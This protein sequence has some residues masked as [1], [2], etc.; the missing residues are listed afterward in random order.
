MKA[1]DRFDELDRVL[2]S[3]LEAPAEQ[4]RS[5]AHQLCEGDAEMLSYLEA[6]LEAARRETLDP[7][8]LTPQQG[9]DR[10]A[11]DRLMGQELAHYRISAKLGEGG[12][13]VVYRALDTKLSREVALK[14]L[15]AGLTHDSRRLARFR[16]EAQV[17]ASLNHP[18]IASIYGL[19]E[20]DGVQLLVMEL[21]PGQTLETRLNEGALPIDD[22][23]EICVQISAA[24]HAAHTAGIVHRDLKPANI[25]VTTDDTGACQVK[26][27]DFGLAKPIE[28]KPTA[29]DLSQSPTITQMTEAGVILGTA[30]YMS[31]EQWRG[32]EVDERTDVWAVGCILFELLTG[33]RAFQGETGTDIAAAVIERDPDFDA[34]PSHAPRRLHAI[35][36]HCLAK[37]RQ[38]RTMSAR[39]IEAELTAIAQDELQDTT[40]GRGSGRLGRRTLIAAFGTTVLALLA[41]WWQGL[42]PN[43]DPDSS[44]LITSLAVLPF[45]DASTGTDSEY[46]AA[47]ITDDLI[48]RLSKIDGLRV[49]PRSVVYSAVTEEKGPVDVAREL[50]VEA[51]VSGLASENGDRLVVSAEL[52]RVADLS[53]L[54]SDRVDGRPV[55]RSARADPTAR[56]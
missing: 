45:E 53:L 5:L 20:V 41:V 32:K 40:R 1:F 3:V 30:H 4:Q 19:E 48:H 46:L 29:T 21:A 14:L 52:L 26:V 15:P 38:Q 33:K 16:R 23:L 13:G 47:G 56:R 12:I 36:R 28:G 22:T 42:G 49:V 25:H 9:A 2:R 34:L 39:E 8:R 17:L 27:L 37:S 54:W 31:P 43:D 24:L 55:F 51:L 50:G 10:E 44:S 7:P 18:N 35:L 11:S 6:M